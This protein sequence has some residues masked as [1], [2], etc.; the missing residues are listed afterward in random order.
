MNRLG[1]QLRRSYDTIRLLYRSRLFNAFVLIVVTLSVGTAGYQ[2]LEGWSFIDALYM[3]VITLTT[4][5]YGE[6]NPLTTR[7]RVFTMILLMT[8]IGIA[9]YAVSTLAAFVVEGEFNR[10]L[11]GRRME[12]KITSLKNHMIVC[13]G[14]HTGQYIVAEFFKTGTPFVLI[15]Y[16]TEVLEHVLQVVGDFPYLRADA[17]Q[18][19]T[20]VLAGI[21]RARGIVTS[22]GEDKDNV[23]IVLSAR[24]LNP[25]LRIVARLIEEK[26]AEKL[27]KAGADEIV[28]ANAIGGMR[29]ASVM[30]RPSVV[31]FLDAML[32]GEGETTRVE[33]VVINPDSALANKSLAALNLSRRLGLLVVAIKTTDGQYHF[34]PSGQ[35]TLRRGDTLIVI[36]ASEKIATLYGKASD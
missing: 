12:R 23:F 33:E 3:T 18:D 34:N 15:E 7:G 19:E 16:N 35:T 10:M 26:N 21:E 28:S 30:I 17:T 24:S 20:L 5:G 29:M 31:T 32:R 27:R 13:G 6:T 8:S 14:G 11:Q 2:V 4:V 1:S 25:R 22:L 9:G 36:G